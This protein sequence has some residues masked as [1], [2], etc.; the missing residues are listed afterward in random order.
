MELNIL[1][2]YYY[3]KRPSPFFSSFSVVQQTQI[4]RIFKNQEKETTRFIFLDLNQFF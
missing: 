1:Y 3:I 4:F 2:I